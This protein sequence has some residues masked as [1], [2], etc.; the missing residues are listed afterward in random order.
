[1]F[2]VLLTTLVG[3]I[4][5]LALTAY[6]VEFFLPVIGA[7]AVLLLTFSLEMNPSDDDRPAAMRDE[8]E[9]HHW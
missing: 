9:R 5:V 4:L 2:T 8:T 6:P 7:A 3:A 1:M